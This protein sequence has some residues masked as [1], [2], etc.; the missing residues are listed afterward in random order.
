MST[1]KPRA[2][3]KTMPAIRPRKTPDSAAS[4]LRVRTLSTTTWM[5]AKTVAAIMTERLCRPGALGSAVTA[6]SETAAISSTNSPRRNQ[7]T[8]G[9]SFDETNDTCPAPPNAT[10]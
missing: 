6:S 9:P 5:R 8:M 1:I 10:R 7:S 3:A 2:N 4:D